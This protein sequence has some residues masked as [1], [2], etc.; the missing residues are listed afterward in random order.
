MEKKRDRRDTRRGVALVINSL[1]L[2]NFEQNLIDRN[3]YESHLGVNKHC[4]F[5]CLSLICKV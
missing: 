1:N 3:N 5:V 2:F 4:I